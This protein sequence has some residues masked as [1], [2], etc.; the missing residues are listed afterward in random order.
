MDQSLMYLHIFYLSKEENEL[1][2]NWFQEFKK[3][4]EASLNEARLKPKY[5]TTESATASGRKVE[6]L[7]AVTQKKPYIRGS[8]ARFKEAEFEEAFKSVSAFTE[9]FT[10]EW[11]LIVRI[12]SDPAHEFYNLVKD[13]LKLICSV[14]IYVSLF[15]LL[16]L[17]LELRHIQIFIYM[18]KLFIHIDVL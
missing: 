12:A 15:F 2:G 17:I 7:K 5:R 3:D 6:L 1:K 11:D 16:F 4:S 14:G 13:M 8:K 9:F 18:H 10:A